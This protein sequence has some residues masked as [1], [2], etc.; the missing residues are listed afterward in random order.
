MFIVGN[1]PNVWRKTHKTEGFSLLTRWK[2]DE[3]GSRTGTPGAHSVVH[4]TG[5]IFASSAC[6]ACDE[7]QACITKVMISARDEVREGCIQ[8]PLKTAHFAKKP[9]TFCIDLSMKV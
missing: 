3:S 2:S 4:G 1:P 8:F 5:G 7:K 9:F 6:A